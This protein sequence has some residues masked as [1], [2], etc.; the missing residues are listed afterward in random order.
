MSVCVCVCAFRGGRFN[1][2]GWGSGL[3]VPWLA[4][5][6]YGLRATTISVERLQTYE[7]RFAWSLKR[8][9][10][11]PKDLRLAEGASTSTHKKTNTPKAILRPT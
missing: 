7:L 3:R 10:G 9:T 5:M 1:F 2:R 8:Y 11:I 4:F 6:G